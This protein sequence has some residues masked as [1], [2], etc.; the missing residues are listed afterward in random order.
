MME[1]VEKVNGILLRLII[2]I[3]KCMNF[4]ERCTICMNFLL[5]S[6]TKVLFKYKIGSL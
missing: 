4:H 6:L 1:E 2:V 3:T 5:R